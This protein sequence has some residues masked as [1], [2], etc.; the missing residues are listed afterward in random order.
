MDG[1]LSGFI[2]CT[3]YTKENIENNRVSVSGNTTDKVEVNTLD[4]EIAITQIKNNKS[5]GYN[6]YLPT[7]LKQQEQSGCKSY[8]VP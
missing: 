3:D 8:I 7:G 2:K 6:E 5:P 1:I 4:L